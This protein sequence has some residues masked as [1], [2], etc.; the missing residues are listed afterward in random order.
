MTQFGFKS[1]LRL[2]DKNQLMLQGDIFQARSRDWR[3][4]AGQ[5]LENAIDM[6]GS[7]FLIKLE[8]QIST[9]SQF[10]LKYYFDR[11]ERHDNS[12]QDDRD[13]Q[14]LELL[15]NNTFNLHELTFGLG[16]RTTSDQTHTPDT[17]RF[18]LNPESDNANE[19]S[20]FVQDKWSISSD[21]TLIYGVKLEDNEQT[22]LESNPSVRALYKF[23]GSQNM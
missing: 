6:N 5:A 16:Y 8:H 14:D 11:F 10:R 19:Q 23:S 20:L 21:L 22:G 4:I 3:L 15:Y 1:E 9:D 2:S 18:S 7:N 13:L 17:G 12:F